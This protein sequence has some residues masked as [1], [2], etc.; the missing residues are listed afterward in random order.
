MENWTDN[1]IKTFNEKCDNLGK[2]IVKSFEMFCNTIEKSINDH[3]KNIK[4]KMKKGE[5][6]ENAH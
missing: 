4:N 3:N 5:K 1:E 2:T 6:Y